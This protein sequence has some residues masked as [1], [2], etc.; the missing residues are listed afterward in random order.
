M[1]DVLVVGA[2]PAG[3]SAAL[4]LKARGCNVVLADEKVGGLIS[5]AAVASHFVGLV[6]GESGTQLAQRMEQQ[7]RLSD[8]EFTGQRVNKLEP[9]DSNWRAICDDGREIQARAVILATGS[10]PKKLTIDGLASDESFSFASQMDA[11]GHILVIGGGDGAAK[12]ALSLLNRGAQSIVMVFPEPALPCIHEFKAQLEHNP[13]VRIVSAAT[14]SQI[15]GDRKTVKVQRDGGAEEITSPS[16]L[17]VLICAGQEP[18]DQLIKDLLPEGYQVTEDNG[19]TS[20]KG[21][22][23]AG[24][25]RAKKVRQVAT[26]T[27]DG[28]TTA[29]AVYTQLQSQ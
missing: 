26:A 6:F 18:N 17:S 25:L 29:I 10:R 7:V 22:W 3:V 21:L 4:Y 13:N 16:P 28:C 9:F 8:I 15:S 1:V 14:V 5:H 27:A 12:E 24:D 23:I 11:K 2:G 20:V 19:A